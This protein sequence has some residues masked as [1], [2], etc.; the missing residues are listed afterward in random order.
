MLSLI[1]EVGYMTLVWVIISFAAVLAFG[2]FLL[3]VNRYVKQV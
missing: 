2:L 3:L 1:Q